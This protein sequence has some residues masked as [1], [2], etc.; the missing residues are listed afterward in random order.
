MKKGIISIIVFAIS[1]FTTIFA[2]ENEWLNGTWYSIYDVIKIKD[3]IIWQTQN[4]CKN[5]FIEA[6]FSLDNNS[7]ILIDGKTAGI[8]ANVNNKILSKHGYPYIKY[9]DFSLPEEFSWL[10]GTWTNGDLFITFT[11]N[12]ISIKDEIDGTQNN[13][14]YV[15]VKENGII[16]PNDNFPDYYELLCLWDEEVG[17]YEECISSYRFSTDNNSLEIDGVGRLER[18]ENN[19]LKDVER[20]YYT[21]RTLYL[22]NYLWI[23]GTWKAADSEELITVSP[24]FYQ[25]G[26]EKKQK[27]IVQ[28]CE[29]S[30][31]GKYICVG[32]LCLDKSSKL[33]Y[34]I[35][36]LGK[37]T[38]L[39]KIENY[40]YWKIALVAILV[41]AI[42]IT[43]MILL[44]KLIIRLIKK[45]IRLIN[46]FIMKIKLAIKKKK[47]Q[48]AH[49]VKEIMS[50]TS[51]SSKRTPL[52]I[53]AIAIF[54]A[55]I[56]VIILFCVG[57]GKKA[58]VGTWTSTKGGSWVF[59]LRS[60]GSAHIT[61]GNVADYDGDW[62]KE[63]QDNY[64]VIRG[65][66][67]T[68][69]FLLYK[70]G[71]VHSW[72]KSRNKVVDDG[73]KMR[74]HKR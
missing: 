63:R 16:K 42:V 72:S 22:G 15:V 46:D 69:A 17:Y 49:K 34:S 25:R 2:Q 20:A 18:N 52:N 55:I 28:E 59:E 36:G 26:N 29:N 12:T 51:D 61:L 32:D 60:D 37:K 4:Y 67:D 57:G 27:C 8:T 54:G 24:F 6:S 38:Y 53:K 35:S 21:K 65:I 23:F 68:K 58:Y 62:T 7:N 45:L 40:Q 71:E 3:N 13:A 30:K 31:I 44:I 66:G 1:S 9:E 64:A 48:I 74:K 50:A 56:V 14:H 70:N 73:I 5:D 47:E 11:E 10:K 43:I 39:E 41:L 33:L 19:M